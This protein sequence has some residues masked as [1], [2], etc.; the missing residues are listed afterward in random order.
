M[1]SLR[2]TACSVKYS[3]ILSFASSGIPFM[4]CRFLRSWRVSVNFVR[5]LKTSDRTDSCNSAKGARVACL[6][7]ESC[8]KQSQSP[9]A[10]GRKGDK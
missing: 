5:A 8:T 4:F 9:A 7:S 2:R 3:L 1:R 10:D 6:S